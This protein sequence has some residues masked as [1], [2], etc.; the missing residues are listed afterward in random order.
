MSPPYMDASEPD[1]PAAE[2]LMKRNCSLSPRQALLVYALLCTAS[3]GIALVF[4]LQGA[5]MV[6][7]FAL[8]ESAAV[9][10]ALLHYSRHA[11]DHERVR[12]QDGCLLVEHADGTRRRVLRL[13]PAH[14]RISLADSGMRTLVDIE[15]RGVRVQV[16]RY[17]TPLARQELVRALR[18]ALR[19]ASLLYPGQKNLL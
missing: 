9:G 17:L 18:Q 10:A 4:T 2:W 13:D 15:A 12:L 16:G 11:L 7:A 14:A 5:W 3:L 1:K 8:V 6:L 19:G